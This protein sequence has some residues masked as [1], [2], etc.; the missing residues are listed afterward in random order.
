MRLKAVCKKAPVAYSGSGKAWS[1]RKETGK[2]NPYSCAVLGGAR[3]TEERQEALQVNSPS[4][5]P[6]VCIFLGSSVHCQ[7][8]TMLHGTILPVHSSLV[9]SFLEPDHSIMARV[10]C[11]ARLHR[12][13]NSVFKSMAF[14]LLCHTS[15]P[16]CLTADGT[17]QTSRPPLTSKAIHST[18][19]RGCRHGRKGF[20]G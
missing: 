9:L 15:S 14:R 2:E 16:T 11:L 17:V 4:I 7:H 12:T 3:R 18:C 8:G 5:T 6:H 1:G 20:Q 10:P 13:S 19:L